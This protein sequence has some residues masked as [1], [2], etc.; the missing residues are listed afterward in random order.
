M[1]LRAVASLAQVSP[2]LLSQIE[3]GDVSPSLLSLVAIADA[4]QVR[5][6]HLLDDPERP[7]DRSP[8]VRRDQ[9]RVI[10]D[11]LCRREYLMHLDDPY[12][13][14]AELTLAPGGFSR[15]SLAAHSGRDYGVVL[16][17]T[18]IVELSTRRERLHEGDYIAFGSGTPHR[19]VN[20][21][22]HDARLAWIIA[23]GHDRIAD[24]PT[25][26]SPA[27]ASAS[28][29]AEETTR[30]IADAGAPRAR[31]QMLGIRL[32]ELRVRRGQTLRAVAER[33][34]VSPS[35][36]S[37]IERGEA[38]PSLL[39]LAA[40]AHALAVRPA[41][42]LD[43]V[44]HDPRSPVVRRSQR[45]VIE[46]PQCRREYMMELD[47]PYLHVAELQIRPRGVSR[48]GPGT[49]SGRDYGL[50]LDGD[51]TLELGDRREQLR[52][53]DYAAFDA[54]EPHR[55]LNETDQPVRM[56]WVMAPAARTDPI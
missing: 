35:L 51:V 27:S 1:S 46:D 3:R 56:L 8:V 42:L 53:G 2:S 17:G 12:L 39:S 11:P 16:E 14:V 45:R 40:I 18:A 21:S 22:D 31:A 6:G 44:E 25:A 52:A 43:S 28:A 10:D 32:R 13:E 50:V 15:P 4:L 5:P 38:S 20:E 55:L 54:R 47:D 26:T 19:I 30:P 9:R 37:Q 49:H 33:A 23:H 48:P 7:V 29:F 36:L 24:A 41:D 34:E